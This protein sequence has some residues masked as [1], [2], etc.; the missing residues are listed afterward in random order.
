MYPL[1]GKY[2]FSRHYITS[3]IPFKSICTPFWV[4]IYSQDIIS[5]LLLHLNLYVHPLRKIFILKTLYHLFHTIPIYLYSLL[6]NYLFSRH[7]ITSTRFQ[8]FC[9][10]SLIN[11]YSLDII[12]PYHS[13]PIYL[14]SQLGKYFFSRHYITSTTP[15]KSICTPTPPTNTHTHTHTHTHS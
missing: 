12:S 4:N 15:F 3:T 13:I 14:Y 6:G 7:H 11:N 1:L 5:P 8:S 10:P 2:L 9:T